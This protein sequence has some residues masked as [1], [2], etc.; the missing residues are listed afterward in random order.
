MRVLVV[1]ANA[2]SKVL[3]NGKTLE[4]MF[5][6]FSPSELAQIF[7]RPQDSEYT[8]FIFC[9]SMYSVSEVD[10]I[11][12]LIF[13]RKRC[14]GEVITKDHSY[15]S[16]IYNN[17]KKKSIKHS[18]LVRDSL[19]GLGLWRNKDLDRWVDKF[20]PEIVFVVSGGSN[21][22][23][24]IARHISISKKIPLVTF[25]TDDYFLYT[26]PHNLLQKIQRLRMKKFYP[27]IVDKSQLLFCIGEL[28]A[29]EYGNYF[30]KNFIPIM[31]AVEKKAYKPFI[32]G[33]GTKKISYFGGLH[34]NRWKMISRLGS[35]LPEDFR[36]EV[37]TLSEISEEIKEEF[38][39]N[40]IIVKDPVSGSE[41]ESKMHS[42]FALL[43]VESDDEE[44]RR[45][46]RLSVSTKIPEYLMMGRLVI[47]FGPKEVA[48]MKLIQDNAIGLYIDSSLDNNIIET[49]LVN[50]LSDVAKCNQLAKRGHEYA[51]DKFDKVK[52][53]RMFRKYLESLI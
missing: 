28:M 11:N 12:K 34:L 48:S 18:A 13:R 17:F 30:K 50:Y 6:E 39:K 46:T 47:G 35:C 10:I 29:E 31:N 16:G 4:A 22:L 44:N 23:N 15:Q 36:I 8:D 37:Y 33:I 52:N 40:K 49:D 21:Y 45:L 42:S 27:Q 41:L 24:S 26:V 2:F 53:A 38:N 20:N 25:Y 14:G 19:W 32:E 1:S 43:H 7:T 9:S 3:N 5:S 51:I